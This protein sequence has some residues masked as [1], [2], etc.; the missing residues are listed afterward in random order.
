[1][2]IFNFGRTMTEKENKISRRVFW[3]VF[4]V[5]AAI[6][7]GFSIFYFGLSKTPSWFS[8]IYDGIIF[9]NFTYFL[10][11]TVPHIKA[12]NK[13]IKAIRKQM[14]EDERRRAFR[15]YHGNETEN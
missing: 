4:G 11:R 2:A 12:V 1:M 9:V 6:F 8:W 15:I 10:L 13:R 14:E 3:I 5:S 7:Y